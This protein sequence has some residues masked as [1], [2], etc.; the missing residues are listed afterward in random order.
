HSTLAHFSH[1][2][3][4][5]QVACASVKRLSPPCTGL[6]PHLTHGPS[7]ALLLPILLYGTDLLVPT[8]ATLM[9]IEV[10]WSQVQRWT[11]HCLRSTPSTIL[12]AKACLP[13]IS[14]LISHKRR[15]A[16]LRIVCSSPSINPTATRHYHSF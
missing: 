11:T 13:P 10:Y 4:L 12:P 15:M 1:R 9:T 5:V 16:T 7:N 2:L 8:K 3:A 6:V 14:T